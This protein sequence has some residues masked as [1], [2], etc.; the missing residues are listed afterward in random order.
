MERG[1][2]ARRRRR[3]TLA[4]SGSGEGVVTRVVKILASFDRDHTAQ[5]PR[6][7]GRRTGL[8]TPTASRLVDEL[9][10]A[11]LP[12]RDERNVVRIGMRLVDCRLQRAGSGRFQTTLK[13][14]REWGAGLCQ[15]EGMHMK[16]PRRSI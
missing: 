1:L 6:A 9:L 14:D 8:P 11:G 13:L 10:E 3:S 7:I 16:K 2:S 12:E 4:N 5:S 15:N